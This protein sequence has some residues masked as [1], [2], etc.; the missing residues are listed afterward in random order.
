MNV[1]GRGRLNALFFILLLLS[2]TPLTSAPAAP[3]P[4]QFR[5]NILAT[6]AT[7]PVPFVENRSTASGGSINYVAQTFGGSLFVSSDGSLTYALIKPG[8]GWGLRERITSNATVSLTASDQIGTVTSFIGNDR[9]SWLN[10]PLFSSIGLAQ[11]SQGVNL[12]ISAYGDRVE[13]R[14]RFAPGTD[15]DHR[16]QR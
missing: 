12:T 11:I 15:L 8:G 9:A 10:R 13:K 3:I 14:F 7:L 2:L 4:D 5:T 6:I 16:E 1:I